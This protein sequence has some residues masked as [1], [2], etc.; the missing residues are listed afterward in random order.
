MSE[1]GEGVDGALD[2]DPSPMRLRSCEDE[3]MLLW[4][5][6]IPHRKRVYIKRVNL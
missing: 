5:Q 1:R 4:Y 3:Q 6:T 2:D